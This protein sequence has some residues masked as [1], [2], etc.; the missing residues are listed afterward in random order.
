[1]RGDVYRER[2]TEVRSLMEWADAEGREHR[3]RRLTAY[4]ARQAEALGRRRGWRF[5]PAAGGGWELRSEPCRFDLRNRREIDPGEVEN[6]TLQAQTIRRRATH[7][8]LAAVGPLPPHELSDR[9]YREVLQP[10]I[11]D[12][13]WGWAEY[14]ER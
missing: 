10:D 5:H 13:V 8:V 6:D 14:R 4:H 7:R 3:V 2:L 9:F 1:M 11:T 12:D